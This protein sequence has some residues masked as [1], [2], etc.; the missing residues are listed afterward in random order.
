MK[1]SSTTQLQKNTR[2]LILPGTLYLTARAWSSLYDNPDSWSWEISLIL[3]ANATSPMTF[4]KKIIN[5][6]RQ[7]FRFFI[8]FYTHHAAFSLIRSCVCCGQL[9]RIFAYLLSYW[10]NNLYQIAHSFKKKKNIN[11]IYWKYY[12]KGRN[13][14]LTTEVWL[15]TQHNKHVTFCVKTRKDPLPRRG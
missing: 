5:N 10:V 11:N 3:G 14:N 1:K 7:L 8:I 4:R 15:S 13:F 2:T 12:S 9:W 6:H